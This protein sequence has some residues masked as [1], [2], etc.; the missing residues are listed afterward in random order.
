M[1]IKNW[2][3]S[4]A[5]A[6]AMASVSMGVTA[7]SVINPKMYMFGFSASFADSVVYFTDIQ[8]VDSV[9]T[10][11]RTDF[12]LAR[13][14][15]SYQLKNYFATHENMPN[16]TCIVMYAK[17]RKKAEKKYIKLRS[18]YTIKG[19]YDVR[20][21]DAAKFKFEAINMRETVK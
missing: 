2:I 10:D 8:A 19:N 1:K 5:V 14:S 18:K 16:R 11:S 12:L 20:Y 15:Y 21:V 17:D 3:G 9:W 13:D 6:V 7:K 4:A